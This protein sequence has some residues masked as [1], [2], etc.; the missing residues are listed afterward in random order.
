MIDAAMSSPQFSG[1]LPNF[2]DDLLEDL[3]ELW[4]LRKDVEKASI[5]MLQRKQFKKYEQLVEDYNQ[6]LARAVQ[7]YRPFVD[8]FALAATQGQLAINNYLMLFQGNAF[9]LEKAFGDVVER[10]LAGLLT[11][12]KIKSFKRE[13]GAD[14]LVVGDVDILL[15][16]K[17]DSIQRKD[18]RQAAN[19]AAEMGYENCALI[20]HRV[21]KEILGYA[22]KLKVP[23]FAYCVKDYFP[24][25]VTIHQLCGMDMPIMKELQTMRFLL[26]G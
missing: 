4:A 26:L 7:L 13:L 11:K 22:D 14:F 16:I 3:Q 21:S 15:E 20:G 8:N 23:V 2:N 1:Q 12:N 9:A 19:Y 18:V 5:I 6:E 24:I 25:I 17:K 10:H